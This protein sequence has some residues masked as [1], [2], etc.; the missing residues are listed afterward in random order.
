[1]S[2]KIAVGVSSINSPF[3]WDK[4]PLPSVKEYWYF[5]TK[6]CLHFQWWIGR[7]FL[8][9]QMRIV[10][11][12]ERSGSVH[13]LTQHHI[14]KERVP[15]LHSC[16]NVKTRNCIVFIFTR[17]LYLVLRFVIRLITSVECTGLQHKTK[18]C[19][20]NCTLLGHYRAS[21]SNFLPTFRDHLS[22]PFSGGQ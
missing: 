14:P 21:S 3:F 6:Y 1:V 17:L 10:H 5:D 9:R 8:P 18:I 19:F 15:Y 12:L 13:T 11:Y 22:V 7:I 2:E 16:E 4:A 20:E